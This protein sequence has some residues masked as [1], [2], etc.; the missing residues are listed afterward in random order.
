MADLLDRLA[1]P[2]DVPV[3]IELD[4]ILVRVPDHLP[5]PN[6]LLSQ[7]VAQSQDLLDG[8]GGIEHHL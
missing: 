3:L 8:D 4:V 7:L 5:D 2:I 6:L 1:H